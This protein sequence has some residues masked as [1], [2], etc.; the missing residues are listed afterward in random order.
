[1]SNLENHPHPEAEF[2]RR[3]DEIESIR[4]RVVELEAALS[5]LIPF[6]QIAFDAEGDTF[7]IQ[8]NDATD[9]LSA[10]ECLLGNR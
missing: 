5:A 10:A 9:A 1:M 3:A 2:D 7:G 8:H 4:S 6:M